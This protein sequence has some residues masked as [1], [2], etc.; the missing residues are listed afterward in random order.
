MK[1]KMINWIREN[2]DQMEAK[3]VRFIYSFMRRILRL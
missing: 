1:E 3:H 2:L